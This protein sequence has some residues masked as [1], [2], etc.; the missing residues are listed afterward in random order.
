[1][2]HA[3]DEVLIMTQNSQ[4]WTNVITPCRSHGSELAAIFT[5]Y[6]ATRVSDERRVG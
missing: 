5:D 4:I 2:Y 1:M 3:L 6:V